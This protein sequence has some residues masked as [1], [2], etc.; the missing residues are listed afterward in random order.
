M[1]KLV[2]IV[3]LL[4]STTALI[5]GIIAIIIVKLFIASGS[6]SDSNSDKELPYIGFKI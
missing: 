4:C 5:V 6:N 3:G 2:L 1:V